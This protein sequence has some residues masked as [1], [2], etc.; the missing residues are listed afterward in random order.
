MKGEKLGEGILSKIERWIAEN[1]KGKVKELPTEY[2]RKK[3]IYWK[4][5][6]F[7]Y[8]PILWKDVPDNIKNLV[9]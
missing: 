2:D 9:I 3:E 4:I 1:Y 8:G 7:V 5:G 6:K